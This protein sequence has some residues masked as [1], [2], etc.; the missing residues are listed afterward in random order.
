MFA[1]SRALGDFEMKN[2]VKAQD[3]TVMTA[4]GDVSVLEWA[5]CE[6]LVIAC[7]G[8]FDVMSS[9]EVSKFVNGRLETGQTPVEVCGRVRRVL[10][11]CSLSRW[12]ALVSGIVALCP[13]LPTPCKDTY[14]NA[15]HSSR[16]RFLLVSLPL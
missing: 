2:P 6:F 12:C 15:P 13:L 7:D 16:P 9:E 1:V 8:I 4:A 11:P 5:G 3:A 10:V 14:L